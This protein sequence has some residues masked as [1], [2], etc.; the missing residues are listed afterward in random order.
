MNMCTL[1]PA[2]TKERES[3]TPLCH[4]PLPAQEKERKKK[5]GKMM[6]PEMVLQCELWLC[7]NTHSHT[8][9][10][11]C[12]DV[13]LHVCIIPPN[14]ILLTNDLIHAIY[15]RVFVCTQ[16]FMCESV[17]ISPPQQYYH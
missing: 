10:R 5:G 17:C 13:H 2:A 7:I 16:S 12:L 9:T 11:R 3:D 1:S 8:H 4:P 6:K 15:E 14:F